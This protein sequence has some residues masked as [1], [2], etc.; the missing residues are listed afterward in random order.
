L[1][2]R[3]NPPPALIKKYSPNPINIK[4]IPFLT[5]TIQFPG[6]GRDFIRPE[7]V[8]ITI[9]IVVIPN[10]K[11]KSI[12]PPI[13]TFFVVDTYRRSPASTGELQGTA[14]R[15]D[16]IPVINAPIYPPLSVVLVEEKRGILIQSIIQKARSRQRLPK[17]TKLQGFVATSPKK[18]P[19]REAI[20]PRIEY[21]MARPKEYV[22]ESVKPLTLLSMFCAP[23][24]PNTIGII[25][26]T[27]GVREPATPPT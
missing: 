1:F 18:L 3:K 12:V 8:P 10:E 20:I 23:T 27:H 5:N 4:A 16:T 14:T 22:R 24:I 7:N 21:T 26:Y 9:R 6:L 17:I 19:V 15:P 25:G 11:K 2:H 13:K